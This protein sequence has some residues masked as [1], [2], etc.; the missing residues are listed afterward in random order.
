MLIDHC[1]DC[2]DILREIGMD[3]NSLGTDLH[4]INSPRILTHCHIKKKTTI[5]TSSIDQ[6]A[7]GLAKYWYFP[8]ATAIDIW[9]P[10][11]P[12][13]RHSH[14]EHLATSVIGFTS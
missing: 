14:M 5:F 12:A 6:G 11:K 2:A 9:L 1:K 10:M 8:G 7:V 3:Q 13:D 4:P